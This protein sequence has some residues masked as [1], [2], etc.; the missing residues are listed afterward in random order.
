MKKQL[1]TF[2][3]DLFM[4]FLGIFI[5]LPVTWAQ[6]DCLGGSEGNSIYLEANNIK[7]LI[8]P[9][10]SLF[11]DGNNAK[12]EVERD[13][14]SLATIFAQGLWIGG[15]DVAG[16]ILV[17]AATYGKSANQY[18]Y[19]PG[20]LL[21]QDLETSIEPDLE[22]CEEWDRTWSVT[23]QEIEAHIA[24]FTDNGIIDNPVST[25]INWPGRGNQNLSFLPVTNQGL[26]PF[27]DRD[28]DGIYEPFAGD[29]P[30]LPQNLESPLPRAD[31][32]TWC[33]FHTGFGLLN[34]SNST[35]SAS[36][37]VQLMAWSFNCSDNELLNN[38]IF[39]T[40]KMIN[41]NISPVED[42]KIGFWHDFDLGCF[43]DDYIGCAPE[44]NTFFVYNATNQDDCQIVTSAGTN[45]P[46]QAVTI[47]NKP[48]D[49][50]IY[51]N[52]GAFGDM[53]ATADPN[54][55]QEYLNYLEG[56]FRDGTP[57]T[58]GGTGFQ[59]GG[60]VT[61]FVFPDDPN[62]AE[63]WS[64]NSAGLPPGD[65]RALGV[66]SLGDMLP[67]QITI[68]DLAYSYHREE[69]ASNLENVTA[70]YE[71]V[72]TI[73]AAYDNY[74]A[75][76]CNQ[77]TAVSEPVWAKNIRLF[78]NPVNE[79]LTIEYGANNIDQIEIWDNYGRCLLKLNEQKNNFEV[80]T[81][82]AGVYYL[83]FGVK[84]ESI[85]RKFVKIK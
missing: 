72:A 21:F 11:W 39:T 85:V 2:T 30:I 81:L 80:G 68:I 66:V 25:V 79:L 74:F 13:G 67:G 17:S 56:S 49:K 70:M 31:Q 38:T 27:W 75:D 16:N 50:F 48:L 36:L 83:K 57:I 44:Q 9:T 1:L 24:D 29:Y 78:P 22:N 42:T 69:G 54:S 3:T 64:M 10:G 35:K 12:F 76:V 51:M 55:E 62:D 34:D 5:L 58:E 4:L 71:N 65:R 46:V 14:N 23:R 61:N 47:L 6:E 77:V 7:A 15:R 53:P 82:P 63:G 20:P 32:M 41:R 19:S 8:D 60:D 18:D 37:E 45:P 33:V 73:Q 28:A 43:E 52:N 59:S 26:A 84:G 40:Y